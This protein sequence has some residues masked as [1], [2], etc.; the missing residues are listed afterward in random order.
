MQRLKR[1]ACFQIQGICGDETIEETI[2]LF[3]MPIRRSG[4]APGIFNDD[5]STGCISLDAFIATSPHHTEKV[6][7]DRGNIRRRLIDAAPAP[8][9]SGKQQSLREGIPGRAVERRQG[10]P[11][12]ILLGKQCDAMRAIGI[13]VDTCDNPLAIPSCLMPLKQKMRAVVVVGIHS[14]EPL[15]DE[16]GILVRLRLRRLDCARGRWAITWSRKH[17]TVNAVSIEPA[18]RS[19]GILQRRAALRHGHF[20]KFRR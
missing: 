6:F 10:S 4:P 15:Q 5:E 19:R 14:M 8:S 7:D 18:R 20:L 2:R 16:I 9:L 3:G 12:L 17:R 11:G 13:Q 1:S